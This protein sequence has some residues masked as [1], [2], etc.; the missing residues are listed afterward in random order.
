MKIPYFIERDPET[1]FFFAIVPSIPGAHT[2]AET[3]EQL[4]K[5]LK[6]VVELCLSELDQEEKESLPE[7]IGMGELEVII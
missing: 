7:F 2:Q 1:G 3:L 4:Q 6:E 5:N